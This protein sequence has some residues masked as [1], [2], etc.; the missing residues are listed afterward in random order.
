MQDAYLRFQAEALSEIESPKTY[1]C[2]IVTRLCLNQ[3]TSARAQRETEEAERAGRALRAAG[4]SGYRLHF[5]ALG[6]PDVSWP[7][8]RVAVFVDGCFWHG[9]P[10]HYRTP[11]TR[12]GWWDA[13]IA[14]NQARAAA[15]DA[16]LRASGWAVV[17]YWEHAAPPMVGIRR[18][19]E[20]W[21]RAWR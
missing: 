8:L 5:R 7:G 16:G 21:R 11:K 12:A 1:L 10:R 4:L 13:K 19:V 14:R 6:R 9:C 20:T 2:A 18:L 17:R 15:V 3:R